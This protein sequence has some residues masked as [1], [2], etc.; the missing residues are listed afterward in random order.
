MFAFHSTKN[1]FYLFT[2]ERM[3]ID[4]FWQIIEKSKERTDRNFD[5][6]IENIIDLLTN[7]PVKSI[8]RFDQI[9]GELYSKLHSSIIWA[10]GELIRG[11]CSDD[12]YDY[13][14]AWLIGQGSRIYTI[15]LTNPDDLADID[16]IA[17]AREY[18]GEL[19]LYAASEA[20]EQKT[21]EDN[22]EELLTEEDFGENMDSLVYIDLELEWIQDGKP[23]EDKLQVML[24]KLYQRFRIGR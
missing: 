1:V 23:I 15:A 3:D 24:P 18:S 16:F 11:H 6:Q 10:S 21:G 7:L 22:F 17:E 8:I 2:Y 4:K 9:I 12:N 13:F 19:L 20:Y 5:K 14:R